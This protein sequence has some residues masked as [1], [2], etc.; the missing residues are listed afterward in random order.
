MYLG[1]EEGDIPKTGILF[2]GWKFSVRKY[3]RV[4]VINDHH[5]CCYLLIKLEPL[6]DV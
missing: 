6:P 4:Y 2:S 1:G 5:Y 3:A